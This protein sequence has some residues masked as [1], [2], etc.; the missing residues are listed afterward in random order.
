MIIRQIISFNS[1]I[2][3]QQSA[4]SLT[5][6]V[7][8]SVSVQFAIHFYAN[9]LMMRFAQNDCEN[10]DTKKCDVTL[11]MSNIMKEAASSEYR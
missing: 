8:S 10:D 5:N 9:S 11:I 1:R 7:L 2:A 3:F 6:I 4:I